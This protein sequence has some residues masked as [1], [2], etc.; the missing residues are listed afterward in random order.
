MR[1][2]RNIDFTTNED[3][4][5]NVFETTIRYMGGLLAAYDL[6]NRKYTILK[7]K[8]VEL[9]NILY[10]AFDTPNRMPMTRWTW[11]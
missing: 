9:G 11:R 3:E 6:S 4:I 10:T 7:T 2:V 5:I 8:A 1:V